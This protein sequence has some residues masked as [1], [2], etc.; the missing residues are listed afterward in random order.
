MGNWQRRRHTYSPVKRPLLALLLLATGWL[1]ATP[2]SSSAANFVAYV[3]CSGFVEAAPSHVCQVGDEPGAF[4]ESDTEV[5]YDVCVE[6]PNTQEICLREELIEPETLF[7]NAITSNIPGTHLVTWF[8]EGAEVASW[9]FRMDAPPA[10]VPMPPAAVVPALTNTKC[11]DA[12]RRVEKLKARLR[13]ATKPKQ[14]VA[15]RAML[16]NARV[17]ARRACG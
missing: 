17:S 16:K 6:F 9:D 8:V 14:K 7:V 4:F 15:I 13:K 10:V 1:L 5:E 2:A 3:G 12:Q 11:R